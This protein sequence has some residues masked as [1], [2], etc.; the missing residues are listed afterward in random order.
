MK[1]SFVKW[2]TLASLSYAACES[3]LLALVGAATRLSVRSLWLPYLLLLACWAVFAPLI[4]WVNRS[5]SNP[6]AYARNF[7]S[8]VSV[9]VFCA[10]SAVAFSVVRLGIFSRAI[11]LSYFVPSIF[12]GVGICW[13]TVYAI[14]LYRPQPP[15][16]Q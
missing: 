13:M 14:G 7:A 6:K 5:Y 11:I 12:L 3:L 2:M 15:E 4:Y 10:V 1:M 9:Y 8:I 16:H